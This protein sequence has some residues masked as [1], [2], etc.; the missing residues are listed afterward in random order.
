[1]SD[2][3]SNLFTPNPDD[4]SPATALQGEYSLDSTLLLVQTLSS[5]ETTDTRLLSDDNASVQQLQARDGEASSSSSSSSSCSAIKSPAGQATNPL[6]GGDDDDD[7]DD[8]DDE[9]KFNFDSFLQKRP[10]PFLFLFRD[11][12]QICPPELFGLSNIP[13]CYNPLVSPGPESVP[14]QEW[15]TLYNVF[16]CKNFPPILF[17]SRFRSSLFSVTK[18]STYLSR[19]KEENR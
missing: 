15:V 19:M 4:L 10:T 1:V 12:A 11:E 5:C 16:A 14:G 2:D 6:G 3:K 18:T 7:D 9:Q 8:D 13:V 17:S